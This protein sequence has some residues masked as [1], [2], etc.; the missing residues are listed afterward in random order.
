MALRALDRAASRRARQGGLVVTQALWKT[1]EDS[2]VARP[3]TCAR[4]G[5]IRTFGRVVAGRMT[6]IAGL[7]TMARVTTNPWIAE[8]V[9]NIA[10]AGNIRARAAV[11]RRTGLAGGA[12]AGA[13]GEARRRKRVVAPKAGVGA[14]TVLR[15]ANIGAVRRAQVA[16]HTASAVPV[17]LACQVFA[18]FVGCGAMP[19]N[20]RTITRI[21]V[22]LGR[23]A[24]TMPDVAAHGIIH[25]RAGDRSIDR[26]AVSRKHRAGVGS[27]VRAWQAIA[28]AA[29][30]RGARRSVQAA[31]A[32]VTVVA[33]SGTRRSL[34]VAAGV[35]VTCRKTVATR[36]HPDW[37]RAARRS[38]QVTGAGRDVAALRGRKHATLPGDPCAYLRVVPSAAL[39]VAGIAGLGTQPET[40]LRVR[41]ALPAAAAGTGLGYDPVAYVVR[42][43]DARIVL[44]VARLR[45]AAV[46]RFRN[47]AHARLRLVGVADACL[48]YQWA[49]VG[50]LGAGGIAPENIVVLVVVLRI[51]R[52][53]PDVAWADLIRRD[54]HRGGRA[55]GGIDAGRSP[56]IVVIAIRACNICRARPRPRSSVGSAVGRIILFTD[57]RPVGIAPE[58]YRHLGGQVDIFDCRC[59][60]IRRHESPCSHGRILRAVGL[61]GR[62]VGQPGV[63]I[64]VVEVAVMGGCGRERPVLVGLAGEPRLGRWRPGRIGITLDAGKCARID[65]A[66]ARR[67]R[68]ADT[69]GAA[70]GADNGA[71]P[72]T[73]AAPTLQIGRACAVGA[74]VADVNGRRGAIGVRQAASGRQIAGRARSAGVVGRIIG[75]IRYAGLLVDVARGHILA[76]AGRGEVGILAVEAAIRAHLAGDV[77]AIFQVLDDVVADDAV[78]KKIEQH[79]RR[80]VD[81]E[82]D[83]RLS[84]V[85]NVERLIGQCSDGS[86]TRRGKGPESDHD[87]ENAG[88]QTPAGKCGK[89]VGHF[90]HPCAGSYR[91]IA[92]TN[93]AVFCGPS[94][95]TVTR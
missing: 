1:V 27:Q 89:R 26:A 15:G 46:A 39:C 71:K 45:R 34:E 57:R 70:G 36:W 28:A 20:G 61:E 62:I 72:M 63:V 12:G 55:V 25:R 49:M 73:D 11:P 30:G 79:R 41:I 7:R 29:A 76:P 56:R 91:S 60:R 9:V 21:V 44:V 19:F 94:T 59:P 8:S 53:G 3:A 58:A 77:A 48:R 47:D 22:A 23:V 74:R 6:Y 84:L 92:C 17:A 54:R 75:G 52:G 2:V 68:L 65:A 13:H 37:G 85:L 69:S 4:A 67:A 93:D 35:L 83:V 50:P 66:R 33:G 38:R 82:H 40:S 42:R 18:H 43:R 5:Q 14:G 32:A 78:G 90:G 80:V 24:G 16:G 88:D 10:R 95:R 51:L 64:D 81:R 86:V 31:D 87:R